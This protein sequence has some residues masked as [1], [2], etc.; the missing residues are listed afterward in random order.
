MGAERL[1]AFE[2]LPLTKDWDSWG[3]CVLIQM[4]MIGTL[5]DMVVGLEWVQNYISYFGGDPNRVTL[6]G[7]SA[8]S[9]S[10]GP[11]A[12]SSF[13]A[14]ER[15]ASMG[16]I[17]TIPNTEDWVVLIYYPLKELLLDTYFGL[18]ETLTI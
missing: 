7:E 9:A 14:E 18:L 11:S 5:L 6:F 15:G 17:G 13:Q 8:G 12:F 3:S 4:K 10:L 2:L 1:G 16:Y